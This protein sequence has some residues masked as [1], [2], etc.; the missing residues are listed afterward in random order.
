MYEMLSSNLRGGMS[1]ASQ[2]Y[3]ESAV[4]QDMHGVP[5]ELDDHGRHSIILDV[6][7]NNLYGC[8]QTFPLPFADFEFLTS[9]ESFGIDWATIDLNGEIGYF[10]EVNLYYPEYIW[11]KTKS[12]PLCPQNIEISY[13][14]LS[15]YQKEVLQEI[16]TKKNY[17]SKKLTATF[18]RREKVVLHAKNLQ[19]FIK[20]GMILEKVFRVI[21]FRQAPF[22]KSWVDFC[23]EKRSK[24]RNEF[25]K[26]F[27]KLLI[28]C[29]F[30]K[31]IE[32]VDN[33]KK[34]KICTDAFSFAKAVRSPTYERHVIVNESISIVVL[35]NTKA[36]VIRPYY[37][38]FSILELSKH[39]M[40]EFFYGVLRP[41]F[42]DQGIQLLYSDTDSLAIEVK[43]YDIIADLQKLEGD[44]D[45]SNLDKNHILFSNKNKAQLFKFKEEFALQPIARLCA[46][47]SKCYSFE[48]ACSHTCGINNKGVCLK[49]NNKKYSPFNV[50]KLKG[51]QKKT[52]RD[53][54]FKKYLKCLE[55]N[56]ARRDMV[57]QITSKAQTISTNLVNK[58]S[59]SSFDDKRYIFNCGVHS[60]P[61]SYKNKPFCKICK[62]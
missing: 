16:Y 61:Y 37:I 25:E 62:F 28:N 34:I 22:M 35:A 10:V 55:K 13:D 3:A 49:C 50:N 45:F 33:R 46:L 53:I 56:H 44:M 7:A 9:E 18:L 58:I 54:H 4:F 59:L 39:V 1:F 52:A 57:F 14:M 26:T 27:F 5:R 32:T 15:P 24:A 19:L 29:I 40:Y 51:I 21:K 38:G 31:C 8:S 48:I 60:E 42:G 6:D 17:K 41:F 43:T 36:K 2:R 11:E 12:F 20:L 47:K 23:T 30:G